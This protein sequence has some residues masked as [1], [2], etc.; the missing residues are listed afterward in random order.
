MYSLIGKEYENHDYVLNMQHVE[1]ANTDIMCN[2]IHY[3]VC[4]DS[5]RVPC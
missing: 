4:G 2:Y 1:I 5:Y 3:Y